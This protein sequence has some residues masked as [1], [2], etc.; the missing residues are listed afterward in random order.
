MPFDYCEI[1]HITWWR[2][3]GPSDIDNLA[4][5]CHKHHHLCHDDGWILTLDPDRVG[6]LTRRMPTAVPV[7][8]PPTTDGVEDQVQGPHRHLE[9]RPPPETHR[10]VPEHL[11]PM[12]C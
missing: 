2:H 5:L 4:P 11:R 9:R 12:R 8:A 10:P 3:G 7:A 1:H 6:H